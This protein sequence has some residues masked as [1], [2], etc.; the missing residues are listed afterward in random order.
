MDIIGEEDGYILGEYSTGH[1]IPNEKNES[2][3]IKLSTIPT[4][5]L[6]K[7]NHFLFLKQLLEDKQDT[8]YILYD[9]LQ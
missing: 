3:S 7:V 1:I 6:E 4:P 8:G 2:V 9:E 5:L